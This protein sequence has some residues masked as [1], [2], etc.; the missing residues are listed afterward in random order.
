MVV[1]LRG[2]A[3][4]GEESYSWL[5]SG[6]GASE[7]F[8]FHRELQGPGPAMPTRK[9]FSLQSYSCEFR[10]HHYGRHDIY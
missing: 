5:G 8:R 4:V 3:T 10:I 6:C 1:I 2:E 7:S 9:M